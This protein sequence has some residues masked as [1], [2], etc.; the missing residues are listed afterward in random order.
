M[1]KKII[2]VFSDEDGENFGVIGNVTRLGALRAIKRFMFYECGL[3][4]EEEITPHID[5]LEKREFWQTD[6]TKYEGG[7]YEDYYWWSKPH[8]IPVVS[9]GTG[10][11]YKL[12]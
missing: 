7:E 12:L 6:D 10:W 8:D 4:D 1:S 2:A 9:V 5:D 11:I 3:D